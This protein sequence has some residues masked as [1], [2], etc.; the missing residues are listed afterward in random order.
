[1]R[2]RIFWVLLW[3]GFASHTQAMDIDGDNVVILFDAS[4]SMETALSG[5]NES[6]LDVA[7]TAIREVTAQLPASTHLGLLVFGGQ[8]SGWVL[9]LGPRDDEALAQALNRI[10]ASGSTPL[11]QNLKIGA[12]V[13]LQK[14]AEQYG[15]GTYRLLVVT[16]GQA[17][18]SDL[19]ETYVPDILT[20][21]L[22]VDVIGVDMRSDHTLAKNVHSYRRANDP[23]SLRQ[24]LREVFAEVGQTRD[25]DTTED[26]FQVLEGF[27]ADLALPVIRAFA[28]SGNHPIEAVTP[29][30]DVDVGDGLI[31]DPSKGSVTPKEEGSGWKT[32]IIIFIA[33]VI[34][35]GRKKKA[36]TAPKGGRT[37]GGAK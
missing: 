2:G 37:R 30:T 8:R 24:A 26:A 16:D 11:G 29:W 20:R 21:G 32:W 17:T 9:P 33:V 28:T 19:M 7:K 36:P 23:E 34:L 18:D 6:R 15:Y 10:T 27:P 3:F 31:S 4:G 22:L 14:R 13:L 1:M 35:F 5:T 12:D 25:G